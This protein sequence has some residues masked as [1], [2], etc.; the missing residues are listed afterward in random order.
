MSRATA[1]N[2]STGPINKVFCRAV[3]PSSMATIFDRETLL[4]L[5]VNAV[6]LGIILFFAV[7]YLVFDPFGNLGFFGELIMIGLHVVPFIGLLIL[8]YVSGKAIA[9]DEARSEVYYQGQAA[10][11]DAPTREE[12]EAD[13]YADEQE[14]EGPPEHEG[15]EGHEGHEE[16][17]TS[18]NR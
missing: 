6:P 11:E 9:G 10:V 2:A 15:H 4:D 14:G 13:L 18:E 5:T 8:T 17:P 16:H 12:A 1:V 7:G 3:Q